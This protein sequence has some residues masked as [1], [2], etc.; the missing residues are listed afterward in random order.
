ME[1][2]TMSQD[3]HRL[4][5]GR[6]VIPPLTERQGQVLSWLITFSEQTG[7]FPTMRETASRFEVTVARIQTLVGQLE[8]HGYLTRIPG[9][10]RNINLTEVAKEWLLRTSERE[11]EP[12]QELPLQPKKN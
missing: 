11:G 8:K 12:Q 3:V 6:P 9:K 2:Q 4:L 5:S 7:H 1:I 10:A